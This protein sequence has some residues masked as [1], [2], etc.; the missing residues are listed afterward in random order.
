MLIIEGGTYTSTKAEEAAF[1]LE[2]GKITINDGHF[3]GCNG[4]L[5]RYSW[6]GEIIINGGNFI[7]NIR[8]AACFESLIITLNSGNYNEGFE[9]EQW[10]EYNYNGTIT[11][12]DNR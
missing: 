10:T 1:G 7:G 12:K 8:G 2:V 5:S 4:G 9:I 11:I 3:I 6:G